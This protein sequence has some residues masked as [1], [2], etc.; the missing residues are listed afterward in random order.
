MAVGWTFS[1]KV[2]RVTISAFLAS[3]G[4]GE[5]TAYV[6]KRIAPGI[7]PASE[8]ASVRFELPANFTG[9]VPLF[10]EL[11]L[12]AGEYWLV[13]GVPRESF[14]EWVAS[15]PLELHLSDV[16]HYLGATQSDLDRIADYTPASRFDTI[17]GRDGYQVEITGIVHGDWCKTR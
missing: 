17:S 7:T 3:G 11:D 10:T 12:P 1:D 2:D 14:V 16:A 5:G 8:I 13:I 4:S 15:S 9:G 6:V